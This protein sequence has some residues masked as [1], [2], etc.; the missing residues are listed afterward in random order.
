M[1][2][3]P[4]RFVT[5]ID[6]NNY[7]VLDAL[8]HPYVVIESVFDIQKGKRTQQMQQGLKL[9]P[10]PTPMMMFLLAIQHLKNQSTDKLHADYVEFDFKDYIKLIK[11]M[12][13]LSTENNITEELPFDTFEKY[14]QTQTNNTI[15]SLEHSGFTRLY[16]TGAIGLPVHGRSTWLAKING[17]GGVTLMEVITVGKSDPYNNTVSINTT[18]LSIP[19]VNKIVKKL[20][21]KDNMRMKKEEKVN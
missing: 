3:K 7:Y 10:L 18:M 21:H 1:L 16:S 4:Y 6:Q 14:E 8:E 19:L 2:G 11:T 15:L 13:D 17:L 5:R 12:Q 9:L 20:E